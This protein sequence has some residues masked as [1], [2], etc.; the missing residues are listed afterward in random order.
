MDGEELNWLWE[1][2]SQKTLYCEQ[3]RQYRSRAGNSWWLR[4]RAAWH[5]QSYLR[6]RERK[7]L[8][9]E[10]SRVQNSVEPSKQIIDFIK[11]KVGYKN[12][13]QGHCVKMERGK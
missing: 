13:L 10:H 11:M 1:H 6:V 2:R 7:A 5:R 9:K 4:L 8:Y 12:W 3:E